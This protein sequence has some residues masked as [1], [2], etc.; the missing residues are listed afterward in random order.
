M[1]CTKSLCCGVPETGTLV[2]LDRTTSVFL[3]ITVVL[4]E[5]EKLGLT[6]MVVGPGIASSVV[7]PMT[8]ICPWRFVC[9][10]RG[11]LVG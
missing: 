9:G 11:I 1:T 2:P 4:P 6:S 8:V 3:E 10:V 5:I 7:L